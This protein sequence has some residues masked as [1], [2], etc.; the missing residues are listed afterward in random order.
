MSS[1]DRNWGRAWE[2]TKR[3]CRSGESWRW[4][5]CSVTVPTGL[6]NPWLH[7]ISRGKS[8]A[9]WKRPKKE[10]FLGQ[11]RAGRWDSLPHI[12]LFSVDSRRKWPGSSVKECCHRRTCHYISQRRTETPAFPQTYLRSLWISNSHVS[13]TFRRGISTPRFLYQVLQNPQKHAK[14]TSQGRWSQSYVP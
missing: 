2:G 7:V 4:W 1:G 9:G 6:I 8:T 13:R 10:S 11:P 5:D 3:G 14:D 12:F